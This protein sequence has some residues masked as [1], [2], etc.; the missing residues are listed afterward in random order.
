M[1]RPGKCIAFGRS[2]SEGSLPNNYNCKMKVKHRSYLQ[3]NNPDHCRQHLNSSSSTPLLDDS[4]CTQQDYDR[5]IQEKDHTI[6]ELKHM[7]Q[8]ID[9]EGKEKSKKGKR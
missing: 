9:R 8:M 4:D 5:I 3:E 2:I 6:R 7:L 1:G